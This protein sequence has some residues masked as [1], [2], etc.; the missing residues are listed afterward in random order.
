MFQSQPNRHISFRSKKFC[1]GGAKMWHFL[2]RMWQKT[3]QVK[4]HIFVRKSVTFFPDM[5]Q[6]W[7][8]TFF[9]HQKKWQM[10][11][12]SPKSETEVWEEIRVRPTLSPVIGLGLQKVK[13]E[14][15]KE[16]MTR[17]VTLP[18]WPI[19]FCILRHG[20]LAVLS[21]RKQKDLITRITQTNNDNSAPQVRSYRVVPGYTNWQIE[22][23]DWNWAGFFTEGLKTRCQRF[24]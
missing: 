3:S 22:T 10:W 2:G 21:L 15:K 12:H 24:R 5:W 6:M 20:A 9:C 14:R 13:K 16:T 19:L 7:R 4:K 18:T 1:T 23:A 8:V 11:R 17:L